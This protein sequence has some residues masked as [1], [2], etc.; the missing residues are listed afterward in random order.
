MF[1][2]LHFLRYS[3]CFHTF[4]SGICDLSVNGTNREKKNTEI[5][6]FWWIGWLGDRDFTPANK[7]RAMFGNISSTVSQP[8]SLFVRAVSLP[9]YHKA[10]NSGQQLIR[11]LKIFPT[12]SSRT[13]HSNLASTRIKGENNMKIKMF[14]PARLCWHEEV[15]MGPF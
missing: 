8:N 7:G 15:L 14:I 9:K 3:K 1:Q 2:W 6:T 10:Q 4:S 12:A 11:T 13:R 5:L